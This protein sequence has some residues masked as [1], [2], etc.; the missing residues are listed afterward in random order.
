MHVRAG[1]SI[2]EQLTMYSKSCILWSGPVCRKKPGTTYRVSATNARSAAVR[3]SPQA[4]LVVEL[5][6]LDEQAWTQVWPAA[7]DG[8][9]GR[10]VREGVVRVG[11]GLSLGQGLRFLLLEVV[12]HSKIGGFGAKSQVKRT[13][14]G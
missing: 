9:H 6:G 12:R 10:I 2:H 1:P 7:L 5:L 13:R 3:W 4:H 14:D 8:C 11:S